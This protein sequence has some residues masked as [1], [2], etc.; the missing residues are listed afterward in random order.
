ML[1]KLQIGAEEQRTEGYGKHDRVTP[2]MMH[3]YDAG[4]LICSHSR[5]VTDR[6]IYVC[7]ILLDAPD[8]K[9]GD[10]L[11]EAATAFPLGHGACYTCYQYGAI[12]TNPSSGFQE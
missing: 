8:A 1:P 7:P 3:G 6:G 5:V 9:L 11:T 2:E 12:C 4:Q 10:T